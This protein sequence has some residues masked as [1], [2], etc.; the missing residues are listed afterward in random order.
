MPVN[1]LIL[2]SASGERGRQALD[3]IASLRLCLFVVSE[4]VYAAIMTKR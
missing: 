1:S 2:S 3:F 4:L